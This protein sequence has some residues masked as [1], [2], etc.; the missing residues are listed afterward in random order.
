MRGMVV[1][2]IINRLNGKLADGTAVFC[3]QQHLHLELET[4]SRRIDQLCHE[5]PG[6]APQAGLGI[7]DLQ[8]GQ[9]PADLAG[10][11]VAEG[12]LPGDPGTVKVTAAQ[13]QVAVMGQHDLPA[14]MDI[15]RYM[16]AVGISGDTASHVRPGA[17]TIIEGVLQ[18]PAFP[19]IYIVGQNG[20]AQL[21]GLR[22]QAVISRTAAVIDDH[23]LIFIFRCQP[24]QQRDHPRV[25]LIGRNE[26]NILSIIHTI[27]SGFESPQIFNH[28]IL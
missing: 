18:G 5:I 3:F 22:V 28:L 9:Q 16:L 25:R 27:T 7:R 14:A 6:D 11:L 2:G 10:Q 19:H 12:A 24:A 17:Q 23:D 8:A 13:D 15:L 26:H 1:L 21:H 20:T 4:F